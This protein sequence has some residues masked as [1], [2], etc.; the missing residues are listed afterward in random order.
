MA[1]SAL[2][3]PA[4][5]FSIDRILRA[6]GFA[7]ELKTAV[8]LGYGR[9]GKSVAEACRS[10][11]LLVYV[12]DQEPERCVQ[13][14]ADGFL[15]PDR[16][17][18]LARADVVLAATGER[19][20][21][22]EDTQIMRDGAFLVSCS[23]K[24]V[25]FDF[26]GIRERYPVKELGTGVHTAIIHGKP[27]HFIYEG[28]PVNFSDG[29]NLGPLLTLLQAEMIAACGDLLRRRFSP[30]VQ[31]PNRDTRRLVIKEWFD[32]YLDRDLGWYRRRTV[33]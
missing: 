29:A 9:V 27:L 2:V 24:D 14:L 20:W 12:F 13:A 1:E 30:G 23:S 18:A 5:L 15:I 31:G 22:E 17:I 4:C 25:E 16:R 28:R 8:V 10:R 7:N 3:G 21:H 6:L 19:S 26:A 32:H 33:M 11:G